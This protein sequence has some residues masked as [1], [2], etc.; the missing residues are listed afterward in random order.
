MGEWFLAFLVALGAKTLV[1]Q[2]VEENCSRCSSKPFLA[3]LGGS[4]K[5]FY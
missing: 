4:N 3:K 2:E 1:V 5:F